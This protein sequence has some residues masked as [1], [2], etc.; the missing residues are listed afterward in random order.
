MGSSQ[1]VRLFIDVAK[2]EVGIGMGLK[3]PLAES[4]E[5]NSPVERKIHLL[6]MSMLTIEQKR[7]QFSV[8][9]AELVRLQRVIS[10]KKLLLTPRRVQSKLG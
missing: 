10:R 6:D 7:L 9:R 5:V 8:R 3:Y 1:L 4:S 2:A